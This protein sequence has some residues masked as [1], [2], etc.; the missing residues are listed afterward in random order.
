VRATL[1]AAGAAIGALSVHAADKVPVQAAPSDDSIAAAKRQLDALKTDSNSTAAGTRTDGLPAISLPNLNTG[2]TS[3]SVVPSNPAAAPTNARNGD[4]WLVDA[5][6]NPSNA[7]TKDPRRQKRDNRPHNSSN[8]RVPGLR[9]LSGATTTADDQLSDAGGRTAQEGSNAKADSTRSDADEKAPSKDTFDPLAQYMASWLA[10]KD[11]ALL[12]PTLDPQ[13][14]SGLANA[15]ASSVDSIAALPGADSRD[16]GLGLS[17]GDKPASL[18]AKPVDNPFLQFLTPPESPASAAPPVT[19]A[20]VF[21]PS[22][23]PP[24]SVTPPPAPESQLPNFVKPN[25]DEK[26]FKPLKRF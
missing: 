7:S 23:A 13:A 2:E 19:P 8:D 20:P 24:P 22:P 1:W 11:Y 15:S 16:G 10:P 6:M 4:N 17:F 21:T 9:E 26:Y 3:P 25:T 14:S 5:M 12:R 18:P